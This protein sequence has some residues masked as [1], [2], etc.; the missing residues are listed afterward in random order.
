MKKIQRLVF[1]FVSCLL[2]SILVSCN[3]P[4]KSINLDSQGDTAT[5][6]LPVD[7]LTTTPSLTQKDDESKEEVKPSATSAEKVEPTS[8]FT[9][10]PPQP[11]DTPAATPSP[12]IIPAGLDI[13][14]IQA[15]GPE[16]D[17]FPKNYNPL[18]GLPVEDPSLLDL[19]AVLAS[20][21]NFPASVRPQSG[22]SFAPQVYEVYITE[23]MTRFLVVFYGRKPEVIPWVSGNYP[24][25]RES[26]APSTL[27]VVLGNRVWLDSNKNGIQD[28][29]EYGVGGVM[30]NLLNADS[31]ARIDSIIT[32]SNGFYGFNVESGKTYLVQV[33][34]PTGFTFSPA[35]QAEND[36]E[37]SDADST[38]VTQPILTSESYDMRWD[39]GLVPPEI[40]FLNQGVTPTVTSEVNIGDQVWNDVNADGVQNL[41]DFG[42]SGVIVNL[43][44]PTSKKMLQT[45]I[46]D[47]NGYYH[48]TVE[49]GSKIILQFIPPEGYSF[50]KADQGGDDRFD[51]DVKK[52]GMT[53]A[54]TAGNEDLYRWDAGV[55][56]PLSMIEGFRSGRQAYAPI[57][58]WYGPDACLVAAGKATTVNVRI[59]RN[60]V[61]YDPNN[62]NA[63]GIDVDQILDIA[64]ENK[65][66]GIDPNYSGNVY[67]V[68]PPEG[69]QDALDLLTFFSSLNQALWRF[70]PLVDGYLRF[71]DRNADG[72]GDFVPTVDRL[73]G[74]HLSFSNLIV[75]FVEHTVV[76]STGTIID[77]N[78]QTTRG[79]AVV[80]R[81]GKMYETV[82]STIGEQYE[83]DTSVA[84]PVKI[85]FADGSPFPLAPGNTWYIVATVG[86]QLWEPSG[87]GQWKFR[88][89]PPEG[90]AQ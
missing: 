71:D 83:K 28:V 25:R 77:L 65:D 16:I 34:A 44:D 38:G 12:T 57:I 58:T 51:S 84:R 67:S 9:P 53:D 80:F 73:T 32:D 21:S 52:N 30:V 76:N 40:S 74:R 82:W 88:Y 42:F 61:N 79:R 29:G 22:L 17:Q 36:R 7:T 4:I 54:F 85:R 87:P 14:G 10:E 2:L 70:D 6:V 89:V 19:P 49:M 56:S 45:T 69:G 47:Y 13:S 81:S 66:S 11:S 43:L 62:I 72:K 24:V 18:T 27:G 41:G 5:A 35:H 59:C 46:T 86:S 26:F 15:V 75:L 78:L 8:T 31:K 50:S 55:I 64:R 33:E 20:I 39:I 60:V 63:A 48:F 23:G 90:A 37:D 1:L 68:L 3:F